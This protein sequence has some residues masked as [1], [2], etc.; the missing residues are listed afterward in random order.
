MIEVSYL[1]IAGLLATGGLL[2]AVGGI[3][4]AVINEIGSTRR[5]TRQR[6]YQIADKGFDLKKDLY[7]AVLTDMHQ[8]A[9]LRMGG[10]GNVALSK[11]E[12]ALSAHNFTLFNIFAPKNA[13]ELAKR[14]AGLLKNEP[15]LDPQKHK[16]Y[17]EN[18]SIR[19]DELTEVVRKEL[20]L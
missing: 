14:A 11:E 19:L 15:P 1:Q 9:M 10:V 2:T 6:E 16:Q 13:R 4:V 17:M 18:L 12:I 3:I 20:Q 8:T 7:L 5:A